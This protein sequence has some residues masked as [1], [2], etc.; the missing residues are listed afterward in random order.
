[1]FDDFHQNNIIHQLRITL[2]KHVKIHIMISGIFSTHDLLYLL[3]STE[4]SRVVRIFIDELSMQK[5]N[6]D[7][8]F[9]SSFTKQSFV[10][11]ELVLIV[12]GEESPVWLNAAI[13]NLV[14]TGM[15]LTTDRLVCLL[16]QSLYTLQVYTAL[17][18]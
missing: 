11:D 12:R 16:T 17:Q 3:G 13:L 7:D 8:Q 18:Y 10:V 1:M 14:E 2:Y 9:L 4:K 5:G 15:L 6:F